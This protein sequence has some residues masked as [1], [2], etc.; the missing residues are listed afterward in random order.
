MAKDLTAARNELSENMQID[1]ILN[2]L[3]SSLNHSKVE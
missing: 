3:P 2:S 1:G